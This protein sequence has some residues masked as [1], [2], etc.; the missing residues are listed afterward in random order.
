[1]LMAGAWMQVWVRA[2]V[3]AWDVGRGCVPWAWAWD[4]LEW[5]GASCLVEQLLQR[6]L[7]GCV[8]DTLVVLEA[9]LTFS[10]VDAM[11]SEVDDAWV[12]QNDLRM[13]R[14]G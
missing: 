10:L 9:Y 3:Q 8:H 11:T 6:C 1:M 5:S 7:V 12:V 13:G 4:S 14:G 2:Q